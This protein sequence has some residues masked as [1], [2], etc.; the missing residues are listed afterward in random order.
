MKKVVLL[1]VFI[2]SASI[3]LAG[4]DEKLTIE[5]K[6]TDIR[7]IAKVICKSGDFGVALEKSVR[8]NLTISI[9]DV[10]VAQAL[11][12]VCQASGF[13]WTK[14]GNTIFIT[15]KKRLENQMKVIKLKNFQAGEM[16]KILLVTIKE[17]IKVAAD[18]SGNSIVLNGAEEAIDKAMMIIGHLD[19]QEQPI[20]LQLKVLRNEEVVFESNFVG[21]PGEKIEFDEAVKFEPVMVGEDKKHNYNSISGFI[22]VEKVSSD[23]S[24]SGRIKAEI[25]HADRKKDSESHRKFAAHFSM[26]TGK[27]K[28]V[29]TSRGKDVVKIFLTVN[30]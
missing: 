14:I 11:D 18:V 3:L 22:R 26:E 5:F 1:F 19:R 23:G 2:L 9:K 17:D 4:L 12:I 6:D 21:M 25:S 16:V 13:S 20:R 24:C 7:D 28:E 15:D 27:A 29:Y 30:P 8:G 10:S